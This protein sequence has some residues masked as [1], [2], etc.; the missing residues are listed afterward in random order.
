[1][2][3][4]QPTK[5]KTD[6]LMVNSVAKAFRVLDAFDAGHPRMTLSEIAE[7]SGLDLSAAQRFTHTLLTLGYLEKDPVTRQFAL[8]LKVLDFSYH[9]KQSSQL[10]ARAMPVL[11]H[12]SKQTE[13]TVN[14]TVLDGTE[15]VYVARIQSRHVLNTDVMTGTRL[16]AYCMSPG[17][18]ILSRMPEA[19][20]QDVIK[21][22]DLRQYTPATVTDPEQLMALIEKTR[23]QGYAVCFEEIFHGDISIAAAIIGPG[24]KVAG[25]VSIA[26]TAARFARDEVETTYAPTIIAAA[27]S[28][29]PP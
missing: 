14:L 10:V 25:A 24:G 26:T 11:Q 9:F 6:P 1:M 13:E 12:L 21:A 19:A 20:A 5:R 7:R 22:S 17:R 3:D 29:S 23:S 18:A 16:P 28:I 4:K 2:T 15:I 27:R 8:A